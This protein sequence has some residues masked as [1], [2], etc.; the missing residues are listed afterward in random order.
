MEDL[1]EGIN[2][3]MDEGARPEVY[4]ELFQNYKNSDW[5]RF[6]SWDPYR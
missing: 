5:E 6:C 1:I 2:I 3:L 4:V